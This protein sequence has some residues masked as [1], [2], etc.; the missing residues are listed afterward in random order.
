MNTNLPQSQEQ[1]HKAL[2]RS[3]FFNCKLLAQ[4]FLFQFADPLE[5]E[6]VHVEL[7]R[8]LNAL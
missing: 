2:K 1:R 7:T 3:P 4:L 6:L 5:A 8:G